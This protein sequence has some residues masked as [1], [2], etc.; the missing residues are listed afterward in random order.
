MLAVILHSLFLICI[1]LYV[2]LIP[3]L[4]LIHPTF[5]QAERI[6]HIVLAFFIIASLPLF[7]FGCVYKKQINAR[8]DHA[9]TPRS[10]FFIFGITFSFIITSLL[11]FPPMSV[12]RIHNQYMHGSHFP[13]IPIT[14]STAIQDAL[15]DAMFV[16]V[17]LMVNLWM[18]QGILTAYRSKMES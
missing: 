5:D 2:V 15:C 12:E 16:I 9:Q 3:E 11:F 1:I 6:L 14:E 4:H 18:Y 13:T 8:L 10:E 17:L 7:G